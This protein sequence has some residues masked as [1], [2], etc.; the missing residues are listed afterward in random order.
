MKKFF[1]L[2]GDI[3]VLKDTVERLSKDLKDLGKEQGE[4]ARQSTENFGH[5]DACQEAVEEQRRIVVSRLHQLTSILNNAVV[6]TP[7]TDKSDTIR[8]GSIVE[9]NDGR[10]MRIGSYMVLA[11][12]DIANIS[13][14]SLLGAELI[15]KEAGDTIEF[16]GNMI[17]I[18]NIA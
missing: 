8:L 3:N 15:G 14:N 16:R 11:H 9:L 18:K 17:Q 6:V 10:I 2:P 4:V 1:F 5:D 12:H 7:P 13:Y